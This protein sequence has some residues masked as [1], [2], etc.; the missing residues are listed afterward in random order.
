MKTTNIGIILLTS[1]VLIKYSTDQFRSSEKSEASVDFVV[2]NFDQSDILLNNQ[3]NDLL[4]VH[5]KTNAER[6]MQKVQ[7]DYFIIE[8]V[9]SIPMNYIS[10]LVHFDANQPSFSEIKTSYKDEYDLARP[11]DNSNTVT[12]ELLM[13]M[14]RR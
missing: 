9:E 4:A 14:P 3:S 2:Y 1:V 10:E 12:N 11:L 6:V 5:A 8:Q 7:S 13:M